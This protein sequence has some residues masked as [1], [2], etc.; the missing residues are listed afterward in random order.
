M[1]SSHPS[2][3]CGISLEETVGIYS[4]MWMDGLARKYGGK[5]LTRT[6]M[7]NDTPV[8]YSKLA[9]HMLNP[10]HG[11]HNRLLRPDHWCQG[12]EGACDC[13]KVPNEVEASNVVDRTPDDVAQPSKGGQMPDGAGNV[14]A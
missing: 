13:T 4:S 2:C 8:N 5:V 10:H 6:E 3:S 1:L 12:S 7:T 9:K 11:Q 14:A